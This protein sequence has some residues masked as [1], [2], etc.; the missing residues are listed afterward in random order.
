[1]HEK[2]HGGTILPNRGKVNGIF[3]KRNRDGEEERVE[4]EIWNKGGGWFTCDARLQCVRK[5]KKIVHRENK[6]E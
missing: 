2:G 4:K 5:I 1:M 6:R 3:V